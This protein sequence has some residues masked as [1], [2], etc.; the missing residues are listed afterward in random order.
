KPDEPEP[1]SEQRDGHDRD[2]RAL[3]ADSAARLARLSAIMDRKSVLP[4]GEAEKQRPAPPRPLALPA[5]DAAQLIEH[6]LATCAALIGSIAEHTNRTMN[7]DSM[8]YFAD[9]IAS[10]MKASADAAKVVAR[11]R[12][13]GPEETRHRILIERVAPQGEGEGVLRT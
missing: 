11:L 10:L 5:G 3:L 12:A 7:L 13:D 8:I 9:R 1:D 2:T 4:A 6:Q